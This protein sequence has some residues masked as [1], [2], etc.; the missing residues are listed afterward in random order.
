M[1][2]LAF[3]GNEE[4]NKVYFS[5]A[6]VSLESIKYDEKGTKYTILTMSNGETIDVVE[7]IEEVLI[8]LRNS[9][10]K[11]SL[12]LFGEPFGFYVN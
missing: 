6:L 1:K 3:F 9:E 12:N 4:R 8:L 10:Q 2:V 11:I 7:S 5:S